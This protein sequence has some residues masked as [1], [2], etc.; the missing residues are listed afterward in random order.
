[1]TVTSAMM[2]R[3]GPLEIDVEDT[4][5]AQLMTDSGV[6]VEVSL[7]YL[8]RRYRRGIEVIGTDATLRLDWAR[9]TLEI[10]NAVEVTQEPVEWAI[11]LSYQREARRL[12]AF[13]DDALKPPVDAISGARSMALAGAIRLCS[14]TSPVR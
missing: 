2:A 8:S 12:L 5:K 3:L 7:D 1:M 9:R 13:A 14:L 11:D 10:E 4:V 6:P